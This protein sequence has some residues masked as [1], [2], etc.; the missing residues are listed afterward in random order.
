MIWIALIVEA[1][2]CGGLV[3][4]LEEEIFSDA[5]SV[6]LELMEEEAAVEIT[7]KIQYEGDAEDFGWVIP[8]PGELISIEQR[9]LQ[10]FE[11]LEA[12]S[13]PK[14]N[15]T[16]HEPL[17]GCNTSKGELSSGGYDSGAFRGV[18]VVGAG[19]AGI[20]DYVVLE[21]S[22]VT[23][24]DG[25]LAENGWS[26][27]STTEA[28]GA[29]VEEGNIQFVALSMSEAILDTGGPYYGSSRSPAATVTLKYGG[30]VLR[31]PAMMSKG[32]SAPQQRTNIYI[33]G[34]QRA[35]VEGWSASEL[36]TL[37]GDFEAYEDAGDL[38][39]SSLIELG[40]GD[41][42]YGVVYSGAFEERWL[43][44]L[45]GVVESGA[46]SLDPIFTLDAGTETA[47]TTLEMFERSKDREKAERKA[48]WFFFLPLLGLGWGMRRID[49][50]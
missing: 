27:G 2:A 42:V 39:T 9:G 36:G 33:L 49:Q 21:A 30:D 7:Y 16:S 23:A 45:D 46:H 35:S 19:S 8:V 48:S 14:I 13:D 26:L 12:V 3:G 40:G 6:V 22:T 38:Y 34:D 37:Y 29:Y 41:R 28:V 25:W 5:Q 32:S 1:W 15:T 44:R 31:Y 10:I 47:Q 4:S 43:T 50:M 24:L 17:L 11:R 20:F 18:D